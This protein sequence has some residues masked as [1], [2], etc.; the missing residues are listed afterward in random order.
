[1]PQRKSLGTLRA[2][3]M[4]GDLAFLKPHKMVWILFLF[5][6]QDSIGEQNTKRGKKDPGVEFRRCGVSS[7]PGGTAGVCRERGYNKKHA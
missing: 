3:V 4:M 1:M 2:S 6:F 5:K 7:A